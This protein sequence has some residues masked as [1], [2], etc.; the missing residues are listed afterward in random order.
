MRPLFLII[1]VALAM[2]ACGTS[3]QAYNGAAANG[4]AN[5]PGPYQG[6]AQPV[7]STPSTAADN[8]AR[9]AQDGANE[10]TPLDQGNSMEDIRITQ[11]IRRGLMNDGDL[12]T[13]AQN[14]KVITRDGHVVLRGPVKDA[15]ESAAVYKI[16]VGVAGVQHV[17]NRTE[18][19][20]RTM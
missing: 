15:A 10:P 8:T 17:D 19:I 16:A 1:P 9:N 13:D 12:S 4:P 20:A 3:H 11:Q 18:A 5:Q 6:P 2:A 7:A 14:I